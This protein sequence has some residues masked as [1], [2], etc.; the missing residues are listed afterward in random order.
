MSI[1]EAS[2]ELGVSRQRVHQMIKTLWND[3]CFK[4]NVEYSSIPR[5]LIPVELVNHHKI[6]THS[7]RDKQIK[8]IKEEINKL[9]EHEKKLN[10]R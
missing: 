2:K 5:W 9:Q 10:E 6:K 7:R 4:I 3:K 8:R 1:M